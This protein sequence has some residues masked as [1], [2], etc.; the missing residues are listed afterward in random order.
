MRIVILADPVDNQRAGIHT[1]TKC[2][3]EAL[4]KIDQKNEYIF[5][6]KKKNEFFNGLS[7]HV[8]PRKAYPGYDTLRR[9]FILPR[10][11]KRLK[12]DI[13]WEP[14]HIGPF[15][16]PKSIKKIVTVHDL[17]PI[18]FPKFHIFRSVLIHKLFFRKTLKNADLILT[19]SENTKKDIKKYLS[20]EK[21][22]E[23][24]PLAIDQPKTNPP[25][26]ETTPGPYIL[27]LGTLEPRKNL[28]LLIEAFLEL[29]KSENLPH[30][31]VLAGEI[32]WKSDKVVKAA[33]NEHIVL[34]NYVTENERASLYAHC[35]LFVYPSLYEGFGLPPLEAMSYGKQ[36]VCSNGGSL[37][38]I[39]SNHA[40]LFS[41]TN[42]TE[43]KSS[44][45][46]AITA[47][48]ITPEKLQEFAKKF[49]WEKTATK[50]LAA[51]NKLLPLL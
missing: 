18:L 16:L 51:I 33:Q 15:R 37:K 11:I 28:E 41:P 40:L 14:C 39:F 36:V 50:T 8:V 4:L 1:Y 27:Y 19:P 10:L 32:G 6:H 31:L 22:I 35:D 38:E 49:T 29:K 46:T 48:P 30:K 47:P 43:L 2:L 7:H 12:P 23:V 5:I 3:I 24:T 45:Q 17:T 9:F 13:V 44:I 26:L 25:R 21:N 20:N 34:T 42:K